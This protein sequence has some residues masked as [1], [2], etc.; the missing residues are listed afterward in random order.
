VQESIS[1]CLVLE[2]LPW[3]QIAQLTKPA[4]D[5]ICNEIEEKWEEQELKEQRLAHKTKFDR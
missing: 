2:Y 4:Q 1:E 3:N 5:W